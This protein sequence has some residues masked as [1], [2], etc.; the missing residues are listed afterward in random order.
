MKI[1]LNLTDNQVQALWWVRG[2]HKDSPKTLEGIFNEWVEDI[3]DI[4]RRNMDELH[5]IAG[6][7]H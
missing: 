5:E 3:E 7:N 1:E 4:F 6:S 2:S